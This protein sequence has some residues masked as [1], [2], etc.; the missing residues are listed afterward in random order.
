MSRRKRS[1][2]VWRSDGI[3][4]EILSKENAYGFHAIS[5]NLPDPAIPC[6]MRGSHRGPS[7]TA[8]VWERHAPQT[9]RLAAFLILSC[10]QACVAG[11]FCLVAQFFVVAMG[12]LMY[13]KSLFSI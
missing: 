7:E 13:K 12:V 9:F 11:N 10:K 2:Q 1:G 3:C 8:L 6:T 5:S 4:L